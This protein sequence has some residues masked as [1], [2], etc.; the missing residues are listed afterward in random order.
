V[1]CLPEASYLLYVDGELAPEQGRPMEAHLVHCRRCRALVVAL[2]EEAELFADVLRGRA[3]PAARPQPEPAGRARALGLAATLVALAAAAAGAAALLESGLPDSLGWLAGLRWSWT[4]AYGLAIHLVLLVRESAPAAFELALPVAAMA[5]ASALLSFA[6]TA[7]RRRMG[8]PGAKL[9]AAF[10]L[11]AA[12]ESRAHFGLHEHE[13][14]LVAAGTVHDGTLVASARSVTVDGIVDGDLVA[15]TERLTLR[16]E[17]RGNLV[18]VAE[19]LDLRGAVEGSLLAGCEQAAVSGE[20]KGDAYVA[21]ETFSLA[22]EGRIGR[23]ATLVADEVVLE[24]ALGRDANALFAGRVEVRGS[25]GRDLG[26]RA[27]RVVLLPGARLGGDVEAA[28]P[29]GVE[30]ERSPGAEVAGA[31][32]TRRREA[33]RGFGLRRFREPRLYAWMLLQIGAGFVLGMLLHLLAPGILAVRA[34]RPRDLL[35]AVGVG[36][37][38]LVAA[39]LALLV[40]AVTVV[41]IPVALIGLGVLLTSLYVALVAVAALVGSALVRPRAGSRSSFGAALAAGLV[42][43]VALTH[44]PFLGGALRVVAVVTGLGLLV[45]R[46]LSAWRERASPVAP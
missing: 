21:G 14:L 41:G 22:R 17:V 12:T 28:L 27:E 31:V 2:R 11:L 33:G 30:V 32:R 20:V 39:P 34:E 4:G 13:D 24:G 16:G 10:V 44:L 45:E 15:L 7:L 42:V 46:A 40:A 3:A 26:A 5:S 36:I 29:A 23:D 35:R 1:S 37:A 43:L 25:V 6:L 8:G 18:A 9:L 38:T 19:E